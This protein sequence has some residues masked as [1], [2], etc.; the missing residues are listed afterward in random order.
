MASV[1]VR[2]GYVI[3]STTPDG[4]AK[5]LENGA[6]FVRDGEIVEVGNYTELKQRYAADE[7]IGSAQH[8]AMP[9]LVNAHH[10]MGLTPF[11]LGIPDMPLEQRVALRWGVRK[12]DLYWGTLY[13]AMQMLE[14]G[15]TTVQHNH[16]SFHPVT[17][18]EEMLKEASQILEVYAKLRMRVAFS[19]CMFDQNRV[20]YGQEAFLNSLPPALASPLR[21][22]LDTID[23]S[24]EAYFSLCEELFKRQGRNQAKL[25]RVFVSPTNVQ[26]CSDALLREVK[27]FAT[28]HQTGIHLHLQETVYQK[29]YGIRTFDKTPLAHLA[30]LGFLGPEVSC[31]HG[32]WLTRED[33][34]LI[35][36]TGTMLTTQPSSNLRTHAGIAPLLP[37]L[38]R[39]VTVAVGIDEATINDDNDMLQELRLL[40]KL[41]RLPGIGHPTLT[42][43]QALHMATVGGAKVTF[44]AD[45]VG[46]LE[47]GKRADLVLVN[48]ERVLEP[49]LDERISIID[50]VLYRAK[51]S[52]VDTVMVD[53]EV[54]LRDKKFPHV[55][56]AEVVQRL[57]ESLVRE[58]TPSER[59]GRRLA[60]EMLPYVTRFFADWQPRHL[61]PYHAYNSAT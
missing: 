25:V 41:H 26:W 53:G 61:S 57:R 56:R 50:A 10:H 3:I 60:E 21:Q 37:I 51:S 22:R 48:L 8:V 58:L 40:T 5:V 28:R 6:V 32:V 33:L 17:S 16:V 47:R 46:T 13:A 55:D 52:D 29:E 2:A 14:S 24:H 43:A 23:I 9:G 1:L 15:I 4:E 11:Q 35:R 54:V 7:E 34:D 18:S 19:W 59:E 42:S 30:D 20:T 36:R 44:F 49:F 31:A 45:R 12:F 38:E 27:E 39:G